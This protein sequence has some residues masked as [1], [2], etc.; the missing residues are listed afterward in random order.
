MHEEAAGRRGF[1]TETAVRA[2]GGP[3]DLLR[4]IH[5]DGH[6][7]KRDLRPRHPF[8][9][10]DPA[11]HRCAR[12]R[13]QSGG[14]EGPA[15]HSARLAVA[16]GIHRHSVPIAHGRISRIR[17][18]AFA[19]GER[20]AVFQLRPRNHGPC[21]GQPALPGR[22]EGV[23]GLHRDGDGVPRRRE[24]AQECAEADGRSVDSGGGARVFSGCK[25][26]TD[27]PLPPATTR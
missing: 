7:R 1:E 11:D 22:G 9:G 19:S 17:H 23:K 10:I 14:V 4:A 5:G 6:A 25:T 16:I 13:P 24:V 15:A 8:A 12:D 2:R 21:H 26:E 20:G 27:P 18:P 3:Q